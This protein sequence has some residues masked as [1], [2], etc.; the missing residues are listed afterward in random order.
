MKSGRPTARAATWPLDSRAGRRST[1]RVFW[2]RPVPRK[3]SSICRWSRWRWQCRRAGRWQSVAAEKQFDSHVVAD[4]ADVGRLHRQRDG[5]DRRAARRRS[6]AVEHQI[7]GV[8]RRAAVAEGDR[9]CRRVQPLVDGDRCVGQ[10]LGLLGGD[11]VRSR[12]SSAAFCRIEAATSASVS[13]GDC[14]LRLPRNGY[15]NAEAPASWPMRLLLEEHVD[16][17]PER[18]IHHLRQFLMDERVVGG[19]AA[20]D[21]RPIGPAIGRPARRGAAL[22]R[23]DS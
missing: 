13:A 19:G 8:G 20:A 14:G 18:V 5:R 21:A 3:C 4:R 15:R 2:L 17:F 11:L 7:V 22:V 1:C 12:S 6:D 16:R 9:A 23:T 10:S